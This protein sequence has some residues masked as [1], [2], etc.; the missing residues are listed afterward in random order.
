MPWKL[1]L[2]EGRR[3]SSIGGR[4][5]INDAVRTGVART[6]RSSGGGRVAWTIAAETVFRSVVGINSSL[7]NDLNKFAVKFF[8]YLKCFEDYTQS[9]FNMNFNV[10]SGFLFPTIFQYYRYFLYLYIYRERERRDTDSCIYMGHYW[11]V[12]LTHMHINLCPPSLEAVPPRA[13]RA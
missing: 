10:Q 9:H 3:R 1:Q 4:R 13:G 11:R 5:N 12:D 2:Q 6:R 8:Q 7:M